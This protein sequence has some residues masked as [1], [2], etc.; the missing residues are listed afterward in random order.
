MI[1]INSIDHIGIRVA[2]KDRAIAFYNLFGF[3][4]ERA[5]DNLSLIHI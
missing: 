3:K 2:D 4:L 1:E 5:A